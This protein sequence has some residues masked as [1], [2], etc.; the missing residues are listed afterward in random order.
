MKTTTECAYLEHSISFFYLYHSISERRAICIGYFPASRTIFVVVV[1][2]YQNKD[3]S[4]LFLEKQFRE[5]CQAV[6]ID[7]QPSSNGVVIKLDYVG[8][9]K[10]AEKILQRA[11]NEHRHQ[12]PGPTIA[13]IECP[14][15]Q[16]MKSG[17]RALDDFPCV[18]IP[19]NARDSHYQVLGWQQV[20][21]K[22]GMQRCAASSQWL[23]ER[24]SLSKYAHVPVGNF[25]LDWLIFTADIFFSR[26]LHDQQ[27]VLWISDDGV[28][29]LGGINE[30]ETCFVDEVHQPVITYPGAYRKITVELKIHH[31]AVN[32][33]LKSNQ[34]NEMEGGALLGYDQDMTSGVHILNEQ[35]GFDE[36]TACAP[37]FRILKQLIQ[38]CLVDAVTF[39][40]VYAD[41]ILQ[42]LYRW[43]C[44]L[45]YLNFDLNGSC[46]W[47][48]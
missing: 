40:N 36:D 37:A 10:D 18:N 3:L 39:G 7:K 41:A 44:R 16:S 38:R 11:I 47:F 9:V 4:P 13:V 30:E 25:E 15:P 31:L 19:S 46:F 1:N 17:I 8:Y 14:H 6:S 26:A 28:P 24:I 21:A 45:Q 35:G 20:A 22:I 29:D 23:N 48:K 12:H 27:Q 2:P 32:G 34:V 43:L 5:A 42:H 33:L